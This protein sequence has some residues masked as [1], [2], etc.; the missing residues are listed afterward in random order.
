MDSHPANTDD[1]N[2][3]ARD[4]N[5]FISENVQKVD[6]KF[7]IADSKLGSLSDVEKFAVNAELRRRTTESEYSKSQLANNTLRAE[8]EAVASLAKPTIPQDVLD[9]LEELK[10]T[11][12]DL[13]YEKKQKLEATLAEQETIARREAHQRAKT[14][15]QSQILQDFNSTLDT[16]LTDEQLQYDIPPRYK[17]NV[18][19]GKWTY[20]EMLEQTHRFLNNSSVAKP[21]AEPE[22]NL[23]SKP[24]GDTPGAP[25][26]AAANTSYTDTIY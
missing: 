25:A 7:S 8:L 14:Q 1:N 12:A 2:N 4:L 5:K 20:I 3:N 18:D 11:D 23:H 13:W 15:T 6:G 26:K 10:H 19:D 24:G 17:K 9:E 22:V 16:P 21:S